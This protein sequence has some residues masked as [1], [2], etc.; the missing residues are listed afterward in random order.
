MGHRRWGD[1]GFF[2]VAFEFESFTRFHPG[3][4]PD[5]WRKCSDCYSEPLSSLQRT[6]D[7]GTDKDS[8]FQSSWRSSEVQGLVLDVIDL[9][10]F[11]KKRGSFKPGSLLGRWVERP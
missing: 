7:I 9:S 5:I 8:A 3:A 1:S 6:E 10:P 2:S 11:Q 4:L